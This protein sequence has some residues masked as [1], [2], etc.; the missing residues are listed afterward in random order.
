[1]KVLNQLVDGVAKLVMGA[2]ACVVFVITFAQVLCRYVFKSPLPWSTDILRLA[3]TYLVFWGGA[4]CVKQKGHLNV[5]FFIT[6]LPEKARKLLEIVIDVIL[7]IF[8]VFLIWHGVKFAQSGLTQTTSYLPIPMTLYYASIPSA[9]VLMLYYMVQ[10]LIEQ[11]GALGGKGE[12][13]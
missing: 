1:M 6:S 9:A 4:W 13:K 5:D 2:S 8:F 11:V 7:C 12:Q 3:F 10:I